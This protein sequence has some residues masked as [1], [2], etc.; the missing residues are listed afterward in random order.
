[1]ENHF[2]CNLDILRAQA[3]HDTLLHG[4][5][6]RSGAGAKDFI[7]SLIKGTMVPIMLTTDVMRTIGM[8]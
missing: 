7:A 8:A 6:D 3:V 1:M 4:Q 5:K 2:G